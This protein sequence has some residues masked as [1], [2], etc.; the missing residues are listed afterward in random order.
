MTHMEW[1]LC[2]MI[3]PELRA[4]TKSTY[5]PLSGAIDVIVI[6]HGFGYCQTL[7]PDIGIYKRQIYVMNE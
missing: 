5:E 7:S 1:K 2:L 3:Y 4:K 6:G